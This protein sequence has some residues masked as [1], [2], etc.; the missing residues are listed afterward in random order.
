MNSNTVSRHYVTA[1]VRHAGTERA[2]EVREFDLMLGAQNQFQARRHEAKRILVQ[3]GYDV[4]GV[5][6]TQL[7]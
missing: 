7:A 5:N 3:I 4:R 2:F 6:I 1:E